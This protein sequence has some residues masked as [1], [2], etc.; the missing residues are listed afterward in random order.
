MHV[1]NN[2][3]RTAENGDIT[4]LVLPPSYYGTNTSDFSLNKLHKTKPTKPTINAWASV[5]GDRFDPDASPIVSAAE[6]LNNPAKSVLTRGLQVPTRHRSLTSGYPFPDILEQ[7]GVTYEEWS[8]FSKE[9]GKHASL[10]KSQ[11]AVTLAGS[12]SLVLLGGLFMGLFAV[13]PATIY[14]DQ[15]RSRGESV[16]FALAD[17]SGALAQCVSRWNRSYFRARGLA[18]RVDIPGRSQD[19]EHMDLSSSKLYQSQQKFGDGTISRWRNERK[20][21]LKDGRARMQASQKGRI[22]ILPLDSRHQPMLHSARVPSGFPGLDGAQDDEVTDDETEVTN[23]DVSVVCPLLARRDR[24]P[25]E[26][27]P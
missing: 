1:S 23:D 6:T 10:S 22:V 24:Y 2:E 21:Q 25:H 12:S 16:N 17:H 26:P 20:D 14:G 18:V 11:W 7:A 27:K 8:A 15:M 9:V 19:M 3:I 13:I 5:P 4:N